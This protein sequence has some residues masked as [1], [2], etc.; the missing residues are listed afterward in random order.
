MCNCDNPLVP[1][2][3]VVKDIK[4]ETSDV[5]TFRISTVDGQKPFTPL[6]GQLAMFSLLPVGEAMFSITGQGEDYLD[7]AIKRCGM[8]TDA[9]HEMSV[10]QQVA[11]R[12]PYGNNFPLESCQGKD[13]LFIG[14]GIGLAPVRSFIGYAFDHREEFGKI[15]IVY[16]ARTPDDLCFKDDL[17]TDWPQKVNTD[18]HITVDNGTDDWQGSVGFVPDYLQSLSFTPENKMVVLCGP[19]IMIKFCLPKLLQMGFEDWQIITTL[20]MKMKCGIGKCGRCNIGSKYVCLDGPVF[21][22]DQLNDLPQEF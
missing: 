19:P 15:D 1:Q 4:Q 5:K 14:G 2:I 3:C 22:L 7:F 10:G 9:L 8:L 20:E 11:L 12:G 18:V 16:G 21:T 13:M 17:F 6:P